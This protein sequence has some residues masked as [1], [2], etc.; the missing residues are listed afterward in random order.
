[1]FVK[2]FLVIVV[3]LVITPFTALADE[4]DELKKKIVLDQKRLVVMQNMEF[5]ED[6]GKAF[7]P[8]FDK[9]Q[10]RLF[11]VN[12]RAA[13]LIIAYASAYQTLTDEQALKI[14]DEYFEIRSERQKI[15]QAFTGELENVLSGKRVF[16]YL[17]VE[18][19]LEAIARFELSRGIP[20][21]Q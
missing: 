17:Q 16:R 7:W 21:A 14:V 4:A 10:E 8:L 1:M 19:K 6:E 9:S 20:L 18:N 12:Q 11:Q 13:T 3:I 5:T 2:S 15:M